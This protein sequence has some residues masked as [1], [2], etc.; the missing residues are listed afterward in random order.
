MDDVIF[1]Q[2]HV[3][4]VIAQYFE[5][6]FRT[7][8][9]L[10]RYVDKTEPCVFFGLYNEMD[11]KLLLDHESYSIVIW[12]GGEF[13][14]YNI[15]FASSLDKC[16]M[17]GY[18]WMEETYRRLNIPFQKLILPVKNYSDFKPT[19]LG[20][21]IYAYSGVHG[22]R[23]SY[24]N[25]N[26]YIH[27]L[28][29]YYGSDKVIYTS[30]KSLEVLIEEYYNNSF[31]YIKP[32]DKGGSTTMWELGYMGRKTVANNQ[33]NL[34]N[35]L[36]FSDLDDIKRHIDAES[37]KIGTIQNELSE[38]VHSVFMNDNAW[39]NLNYY[40]EYFSRRNTNR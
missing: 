39:L 18:G 1:K 38:Q 2:A 3:S 33:G 9:N 19:P 26:S 22:N 29:D 40:E 25:W 21:K 16:I 27:P 17:V 4:K 13:E 30:F 31:I 5:E 10:D 32:K 15:K 12:G 7:R 8:W 28:I 20:D 34:P 6:N 37:K 24:L 14:D 11:R 23:G 36:N 35:V